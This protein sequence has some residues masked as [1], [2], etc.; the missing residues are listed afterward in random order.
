MGRSLKDGSKVLATPIAQICNLSVKP[1]TVP[2][3]HKITKLKEICRPIPLLPVISKTLKK[4]IHDQTMEFVTKKNIFYKFQSGF[5]KFH[6]TDS[7]FSYL[8]D[9]VANGFDSGL[10]TGMILIDTID[11][12]ILT[13]KMKSMCFSND[14]TKWFEC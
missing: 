10:L 9:N 4:V 11:Y 13:K 6:S 12:K 2:D 7:C 14:V 3:E 1:S 5:Q 8:Q